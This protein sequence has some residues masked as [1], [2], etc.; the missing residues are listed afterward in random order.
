MKSAALGLALVLVATG[1][2]ADENHRAVYEVSITNI[3]KG[4]TFTPQLITIHRGSVSLFPL[5]EPASQQLEVLAEDGSTGPLTE[6]LE[7]QGRSVGAVT[8]IGALLQP[9]QTATA[10]LEAP[11]NHDFL[12]AAGM[13]IPTNDTFFAVNRQRLP[14][15]GSVTVFAQ[16]YD[17]GTEAN[18]QNC[19]N[20]PGPRCGGEGLSAGINPGDEG[21]VHIGNG[22][23]ELGASET[24]GEILGP[25]QYDWRNPV[26][27]I[28]IQRVR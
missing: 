15:S 19:S 10:M 11:A 9:G 27:M 5:G 16:A 1:T 22:F 23:H 21:F 6:L 8:T 4:Q 18:D 13:L 3:T 2:L 7:S 28:R 26:A 20:I 25:F 14:K 12:S 24:P 17:A